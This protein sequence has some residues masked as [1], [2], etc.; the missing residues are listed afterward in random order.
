LLSGSQT[1]SLARQEA[2]SS[3]TFCESEKK[4]K[5]RKKGGNKE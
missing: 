2:W 1:P 5:K 3:L 4:E